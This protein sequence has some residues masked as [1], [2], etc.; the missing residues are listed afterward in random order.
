VAA[1]HTGSYLAICQ[2]DDRS[3]GNEEPAGPHRTAWRN[4]SWPSQLRDWPY[5]RGR[6]HDWSASQTKTAASGEATVPDHYHNL[7]KVVGGARN[8]PYLL[9]LFARILI[10]SWWQRGA[11]ATSAK[12]Q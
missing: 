3:I 6:Q 10:S 4:T 2:C 11:D 7:V 12:L 9:L 1:E 8:R 5:G